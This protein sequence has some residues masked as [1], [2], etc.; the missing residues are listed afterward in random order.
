ME[1][2]KDDPW[3]LV[4]AHGGLDFLNLCKLEHE[5]KEQGRGLQISPG[6]FALTLARGD[7]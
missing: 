6:F 1:A 2:A 5:P 4:Q 3:T 7:C